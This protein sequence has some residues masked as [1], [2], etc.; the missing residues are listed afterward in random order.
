MRHGSSI[1]RDGSILLED[2]GGLDSFVIFKTLTKVHGVVKKQLH[3]LSNDS[4]D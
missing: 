2:L 3:S 1:K 4:R